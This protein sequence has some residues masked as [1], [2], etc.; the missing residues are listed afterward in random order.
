MSNLWG[1]VD[2]DDNR[3]YAVVGVSNATVVIDVT[4]PENPREVGLGAR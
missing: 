2:L 3:E 1:F 4:D